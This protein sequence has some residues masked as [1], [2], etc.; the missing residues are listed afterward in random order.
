MDRLSAIRVPTL[1]VGG[2]QDAMTPPKFVQYL[3]GTI[4]GAELALLEGAGH[5]PMV[6]QADAFNQ[7]LAAFLARLD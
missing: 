5:Y 7:R 2:A 6:E 4:P 3:A 1:V